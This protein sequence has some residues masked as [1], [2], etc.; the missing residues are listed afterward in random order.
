MKQIGKYKILGTLG[1]G[2][3]G[4]VYKALDPDIE[5]EV[6]IKT[7]RFDTLTEGMEKEEL[8]TR[9]IRE[10]KAAGRL[11]H[12]NIITI[13]DV[14]RDKDLTYIVMQY[15]D[16]PSLQTVIDSGKSFSPQEIIDTLKPVSEALDFAHEGGIVHR[17]IKPANIL[18][19]KSGQPFL[20]DFGVARI[21]TSTLTLAGTT[22]GTL[23]YMSPEQV[24]GQTVDKRSDIFALGVILY[25]LLTGK[26]PFGGDNMS[27][28][29]YRIVNEEPQRV[30]E[31]NREL[32][33]GYE[34]VVRRALAKN[35]EDRYQSCREM[36]TDL[37]NPSR[38]AEATLAYDFSQEAG[39]EPKKRKMTFVLA[40]AA[41]LVALIAGG[42]Y[43]LFSG[44]SEKPS[45]LAQNLET[46]KKEGLS[47]V[48]RSA[49][50]AA[51]TAAA[52]TAPSDEGQAKLRESFDGKAYQET[53]RLADEILARDPANVP[54]KEYLNKARAEILAPQVAPLLQS[55]IS[56][57]ADGNY[58][59][60]ITDMEKV[61]K[62]DKDNK[63]AQ[64]HLFQADTALSKPEITA[65]I[66][67]HRVAEENKDLLTVLSLFDSPALAD[68]LQAEYKLLFNGYDGIKSIISKVS[69]SFS[70]RTSATASYSQL[71]TAV[72]KKTG[73]RKI[74]FEGQ[75]TWRLRRQG[76]DWK[77]SAVQ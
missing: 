4:I 9:V 74:V 45:D 8:L 47:P 7:I 14:V 65:M 22:V 32:H 56:S 34:S 64:K 52:L 17:D 49:G 53:V 30:T 38:M 72:Y 44:R 68:S 43:L 35:P 13:Y 76:K 12:P 48:T 31:I 21:E 54:A 61:L 33:G 26:K 6:A 11:N 60:C 39:G 10:A 28:I 46:I 75:K 77:I 50:P 5:R 41:A 40:G 36:I 18:I 23:S 70:S 19:D 27:T 67:R 55:G 16:G 73:Q 71:L 63:D 57:Y 29:V 42:A 37:E 24:K 15:V 1:K 20:A 62:I 3:M 25:E 66:E 59:Q 51:G 69:L 58:A 2:G